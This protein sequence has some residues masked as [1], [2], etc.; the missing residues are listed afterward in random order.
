MTDFS[1]IA[2]VRAVIEETDLASPVEIADKVIEMVPR[3]AVRAALVEALP[4]VVQAELSRQPRSAGPQAAT[5]TVRRI[6]N[7]SAK[8]RAIRQ[9]AEEWR[10]RLRHRI[11]V[12]GGEWKFLADCTATDFR[13][14]ATR[15]R[16]HA[17]GALANAVEFEAYAAALDEHKVSRFA[18]LPEDV[19]AALLGAEESAA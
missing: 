18:D 2:T 8:V 10:A 15:R 12:G 14:A 1:L 17:A 13:T 16:A 6:Q 3:A 7:P 11:S 9:H 19:Q 5:E 4:Y